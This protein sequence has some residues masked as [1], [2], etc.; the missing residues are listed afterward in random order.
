[1]TEIYRYIQLRL[2]FLA[3]AGFCF[4][5]AVVD[6]HLI[7]YLSGS[8]EYPFRFLRFSYRPAVKDSLAKSS[9]HHLSIGIQQGGFM[10]YVSDGIN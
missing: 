8:L 1:M 6:K 10:G 7:H 4:G 3:A 2:V 5:S 9:D